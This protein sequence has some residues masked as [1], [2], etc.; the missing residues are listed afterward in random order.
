[1]IVLLAGGLA[2]RSTTPEAEQGTDRRPTDTA[3]ASR[4]ADSASS[5]VLL[6]TDK[7]R[8]QPG[9]RLTLTLTNR[10]GATYAFNPC[11]RLIERES[12]STWTSYAEPNR[13]CTM[14]AWL[15]GPNATRT[16]ATELPAQLPSGR[17]RIV[18]LLSRQGAAPPGSEAAPEHARAVSPPIEVAP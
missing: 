12:G 5:A 18:V 2:C 6:R 3:A 1:M 11:T 7:S 15:L 10:T 16:G 17:Y 4:D 13:M 14:E 8:Y 9:A